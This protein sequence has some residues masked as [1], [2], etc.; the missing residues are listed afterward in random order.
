MCL[1]H[2]L[3]EKEYL[4]VREKGWKDPTIPEMSKPHLNVLSGMTMRY[5]VTWPAFSLGSLRQTLSAPPLLHTMGLISFQ[6]P[7]TWNLLLTKLY[8]TWNYETHSA[9]CSIY[10]IN[11]HGNI[12]CHSPNPALNYMF[13]ILSTHLGTFSKTPYTLLLC[14][15]GP[16]FP[17]VSSAEG[18]QWHHSGSVGKDKR[19]F[20]SFQQNFRN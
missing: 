3:G 10:Q 8:F 13:K 6:S 7:D 17:P 12:Y 16:I 18:F 11:P 20:L 15:R 1:Q 4:M 5:N 19:W 14:Q 2:D 9:Q